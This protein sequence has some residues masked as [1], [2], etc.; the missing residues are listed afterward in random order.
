MRRPRG[1]EGLERDDSADT[2]DRGGPL[3]YIPLDLI[4]LFRR[5]PFAVRIQFTAPPSTM[6]A[7]V[8]LREKAR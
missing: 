4:L 1:H 6:P 2:F 3:S 7:L 5:H 8:I